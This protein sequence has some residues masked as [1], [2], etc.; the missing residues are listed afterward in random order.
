MTRAIL[1]ETLVLLV[2][3]KMTELATTQYDVMFP[4][5][6][7]K[8]INEPNPVKVLHERFKHHDVWVSDDGFE[9]A[10]TNK[11]AYRRNDLAFSRM[12][13]MEIDKR[14]QSHGQLPDYSTVG[15][16]EHMI[17]QTLDERW[18]TY[19][20]AEAEDDYLPIVI[21][22]IGNLCLLSGPANSAAGRD[23]FEAK[24]AGYSPL[25]ALARQIKEHTGHW[26]MKAVR[27][28]S[29]KLAKEAVEIWAWAN[30]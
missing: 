28:R 7:G 30:V 10:L 17:P 4:S 26:D 29:Q 18:K 24:K 9:E 27:D 2:R 5:L 20:G 14:L 8:I 6:L 21:N 25:T 19:L 15:T 12:L 11:T 23:P 22:T 13:L 16:I 3:R 1:R